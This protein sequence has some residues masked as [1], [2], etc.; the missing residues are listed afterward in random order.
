[1][2]KSFLLAR[3]VASMFPKYVGL[4]LLGTTPQRVEKELDVNQYLSKDY[5]NMY[6]MEMYDFDEEVLK[7]ENDNFIFILNFHEPTS[8]IWLSSPISG[9]HHFELKDKNDFKSWKSTRDQTLGLY[10]LIL[11]ELKKSNDQ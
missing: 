6:K 7:F 2:T 11:S 9:A 8:Q 1:M 3:I 5:S 10:D 4:S